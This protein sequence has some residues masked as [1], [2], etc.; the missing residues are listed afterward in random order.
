MSDS[1]KSY[2]SFEEEH[3]LPYTTTTNT[4]STTTT[5]TLTITTTATTDTDRVSGTTDA[6]SS[7]FPLVSMTIP[8]STS[9]VIYPI[10]RLESQFF[11]RAIER[12]GLQHS[13]GLYI[14]STPICK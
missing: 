10:H 14:E 8:V 6:S 13:E 7:H 5:A 1:N 12:R 2:W 9:D 4:I 11:E 3:C